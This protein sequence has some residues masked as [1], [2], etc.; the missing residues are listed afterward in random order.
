M[1]SMTFSGSTMHKCFHGA[2]NVGV[3]SEG[4]WLLL[5]GWCRVWEI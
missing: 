4:S 5:D 2:N 3:L 1:S